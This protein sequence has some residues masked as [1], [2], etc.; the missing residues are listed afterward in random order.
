MNKA[1]LVEKVQTVLGGTKVQAEEVVETIFDA[2]ANSVKKGEDVAIAGFGK[3]SRKESKAREARNPKTGE[4][5]KVPAS[6]K[7]K[8]AAA[9]AFKDLVK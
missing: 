3:F 4:M 9:K 5:V 2:I 6:K 1:A 8:F 7:P